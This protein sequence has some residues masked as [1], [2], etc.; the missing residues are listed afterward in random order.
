MILHKIQPLSLV[1]KQITQRTNC[2]CCQIQKKTTAR[3]S[4][5]AIMQINSLGTY[6]RNVLTRRLNGDPNKCAEFNN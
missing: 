2:G 4:A 5:A 1:F 3:L 6:S